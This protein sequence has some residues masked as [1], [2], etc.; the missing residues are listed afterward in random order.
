MLHL[1]EIGIHLPDFFLFHTLVFIII[2]FLFLFSREGYLLLE[3]AEERFH[4]HLRLPF[5]KRET[6]PDRD[7]KHKD[8]Q[9]QNSD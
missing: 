9:K 4:R 1:L 7:Q 3:K 2:R 8:D 5:L 6:V